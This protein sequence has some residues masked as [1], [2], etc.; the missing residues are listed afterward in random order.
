MAHPTADESK[1]RDPRVAARA[2]AA[3]DRPMSGSAPGGMEQDLPARARII[4]PSLLLPAEVVL[5]ELKPSLWYV[6]FES[7]PLASLGAVLVLLGL[8][9]YEL[10]NSVRQW[11]IL[12]GISIIGLRVTAAF[13]QW[14]GRTYVLTDRRILTQYGVL[15]VAVECL[16]LEEIENL[17]VAQAAVQRLLGIGTIFFRCGAANPRP[18]AWEHLREPQKVRARIALQID[19]WK[20]SLS[21][22]KGA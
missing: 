18:L 15:S 12:L 11:G 1:A 21:M 16:G 8:G 6:V 4:A 20:H 5:L 7:L 22:S 17:F 19:R 3:P 2:A 9:V 14:L 10:P 13:L